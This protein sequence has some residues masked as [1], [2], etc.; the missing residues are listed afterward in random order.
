MTQGDNT[1][2]Y[3]S[4]SK[5]KISSKSKYK[6]ALSQVMSNIQ[7]LQQRHDLKNV[8]ETCFSIYT[9]ALTESTVSF[10]FFPTFDKKSSPTTKTNS[11]ILQYIS[12]ALY[13][14]KQPSMPAAGLYP[15]VLNTVAEADVSFIGLIESTP[16]KYSQSLNLLEEM[17]SL[18]KGRSSA[19]LSSK[20]NVPVQGNVSKPKSTTSRASSASRDDNLDRDAR[21]LMKEIDEFILQSEEVIVNLF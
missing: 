8:Y 10:V 19:L 21:L 2:G 14:Q 18:A 5:S 12:R 1:G 17:E 7:Q 4:N 11:E 15:A 3:A 16:E 9:F 20:R 6:S 13:N